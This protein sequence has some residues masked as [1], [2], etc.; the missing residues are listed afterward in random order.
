MSTQ[1]ADEIDRADPDR[2]IGY[3]RGQTNS[4]GQSADYIGLR[5]MMPAGGAVLSARDTH[6]FALALLRYRL[7]DSVNTNVA[8]TGIVQYR[9][10]AR[11]GYG[12]ANELVNGKRIVFHDGGADGISANLDLIPERGLIAIVLTNLYPPAAR[13]IRDALRAEMLFRTG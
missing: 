7:L 13:P 8:T 10:G 5:R 9:P 2:A 4:S 12:F 1:P 6:R 11:Y 3:T